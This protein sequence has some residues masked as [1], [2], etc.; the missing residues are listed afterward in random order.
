MA[1]I[2]PILDSTKISL[3][4]AAADKFGAAVEQFATG[5]IGPALG[6]TP[7]SPAGTTTRPND[8][9]FYSSSYAAALAGG[10]SY[11]PKLKFLFKVEFVFTEEAKKA[12]PGV[13][14]AATSQ[15]FTFMI[16]SVDL[17][18]IDFEYEEDINMYNFRTKALKKIRHRELTL[19]LMNDT[20]NRVLNFFRAV[21]MLHSPITRRQMRRQNGSYEDRIRAPEALSIQEGNGMNFAAANDAS[22]NDTAIR[23]TIESQVGNVI[24]SIRVK[25]MYVNP[26]SQ[27]GA[28]V[29]ETIF[30]FLNARLVSFDLDDLSHE[31]SDANLVTMQFDYD[32]M[33]IVQV[34]ALVKTDSPNYNIAVPGVHGAPSDI[35][36]AGTA[37]TSAGGGNVFTNILTNQLGRATQSIT[38]SAIN[39]A[40][41]TIAGKGQFASLIGSQTS[42]I[43][44]GLVGAAS[45]NIGS[46]LINQA[47]A[48]FTKVNVITPPSISPAGTSSVMD[49]TTGGR[50]DL[51]SVVTTSFDADLSG[52]TGD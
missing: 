11:R 6:I 4:R 18:K 1:N 25:Q 40:V 29:E 14:G 15:D 24:Q 34:G 23:G 3:E 50:S 5:T 8:G 7:E 16:K 13:L 39:K 46:G 36:P 52:Y 12:F 51:S 19:T 43:L 9:S 38:S 31:S 28:A 45:R 10:T 20:G 48:A 26:G 17:P 42:N 22:T 49:S 37:T 33:E 41:A 30:D 35:S 27:L 21:M 47:G 44:G 32:W 2:S